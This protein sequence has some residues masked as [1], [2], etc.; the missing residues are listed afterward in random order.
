MSRQEW[1]VIA[2]FANRRAAEHM[3]A[4]LGRNFRRR[5][6]K[7]QA[8]AFVI[9]GNADGS[10]KLRKSRV[11]EA[12][13][14]ASTIARV[15]AFV[16]VGLIGIVAMVKGVKGGRRAAQKHESHV[17]SDEH[18]AH[19]I[20]AQAGP[21][22]AIT[23][24]RCRDAEIQK[25]VATGASNQATYSWSGPMEDFLAALEPGSTHDWVRAALDQ[26]L[27]AKT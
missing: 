17:G 10:L 15:A 4:A 1:V 18:R 22:A 25:V 14:F 19:S 7:G 8:E 6:N 27:S 9:T 12:G 2:S 26:P 24:V 5:A 13:G 20:L 21:D 3:L 16:M 23:L 11:L